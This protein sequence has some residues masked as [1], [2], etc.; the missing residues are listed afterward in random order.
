MGVGVEQA[1]ALVGVCWL[2]GGRTSPIVEMGSSRA[3]GMLAGRP[4][5]APPAASRGHVT[6][7]APRRMT[8]I[9]RE[10]L[11]R[12]TARSV[13]LQRAGRPDVVAES[14]CDRRR[15]WVSRG[16]A[17]RANCGGRTEPTEGVGRAR[18]PVVALVHR[19]RCH[20]RQL[21]LVRAEAE[22]EQLCGREGR[23]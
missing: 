11:E 22:S 9:R 21:D 8:C 16:A 2:V 7:R 19:E 13:V 5:S 12:A 14:S 18:L 10:I 17:H 4:L 20:R 15:G 3:I 1:E 23:E 6:V